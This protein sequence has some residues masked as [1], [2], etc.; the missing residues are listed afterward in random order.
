MIASSYS[1]SVQLS[2]DLPQCQTLRSFVPLDGQHI[3]WKSLL[4]P[5]N[6]YCASFLDICKMYVSDLSSFSTIQSWSFSGSKFILT[7]IPVFS[8][9]A[10]G[11]TSNASANLTI[12]YCSRPGHVCK[13]K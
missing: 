7:L 10:L 13:F 12:A 8:A 9:S 5:E 11:R 3:T 6:L 2:R 4:L 1:Q